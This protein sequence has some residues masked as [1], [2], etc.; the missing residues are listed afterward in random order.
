MGY[1]WVRQEVNNQQESL[2][3]WGILEDICKQHNL[4]GPI[5]NSEAQQLECGSDTHPYGKLINNITA[6]G[7]LY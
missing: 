4:S 1:S 5:W 3:P 7:K 6:A 2:K